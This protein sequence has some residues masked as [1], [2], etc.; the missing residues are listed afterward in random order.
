MRDPPKEITDCHFLIKGLREV[1][2]MKDRELL[3]L[4]LTRQEYEKKLGMEPP[5]KFIEEMNK[6]REENARF[7]N[8]I[9]ELEKEVKT[10]TKIQKNQSDALIGA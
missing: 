3:G 1:I 10:L 8:R 7:K 6:L 2:I 4:K 9:S 5:A